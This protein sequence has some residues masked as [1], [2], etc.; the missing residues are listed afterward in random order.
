MNSGG[1]K[2]SVQGPPSLLYNGYWVLTGVKWP[3][4]G[5]HHR[6]PSSAGLQMGRSCTS[7]SPLCQQTCHGVT[8]IFSIKLYVGHSNSSTNIT[9]TIMPNK[10]SF[11]SHIHQVC[12]PTVGCEHH[13]LHFSL[14]NHGII[15]FS[16][17]ISFFVQFPVVHDSLGSNALHSSSSK[18]PQPVLT[19]PLP[20]YTLC[21]F[22][23]SSMHN[24][25]N[26]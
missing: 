19:P 22:F 9:F 6:P 16:L 13:I 17:R 3:E 25:P 14:K 8:F 23:Q 15:T 12:V 26:T 18:Y 2:F 21:I 4:C 7:T 10:I 24:L 11:I 5:A 20:P 1:V